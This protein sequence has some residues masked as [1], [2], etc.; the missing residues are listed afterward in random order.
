MPNT[1]TETPYTIRENLTESIDAIWDHLASPGSWWTGAQR[2]AIA[3][4]SRNAWSCAFCVSNKAALS[5][6]AAKGRHDSTVDLPEPAIDAIHRITTDPGRL[7]KSWYEGLVAEGLNPEEYV[8]IVAVIGHLTCVDTFH[9]ALGV[10]ARPL[11]EPKDG[12]PT[13]D[14]S[15][16][17]E[18]TMAWVPTVSHKNATGALAEEWF[19]GGKKGFVPHVAQSL[20]L[21]PTEAIGFKRNVMS[22][23]YLNTGSINDPTADIGS[24]K[25]PQAEL[26]AARTSALN[27]CF[28]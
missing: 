11:P 3:R 19:P 20:T 27:E 21:L 12:A 24:L 1:L 8:E 28:Y 14:R 15:H 23:F 5:P 16:N 22:Q 10:A 13:G 7:T 6:Y 18:V 2:V 25:R 17:A 4:E 9:R 26:L